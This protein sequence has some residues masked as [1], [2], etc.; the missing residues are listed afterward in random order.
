MRGRVRAGAGDR[1]SRGRRPRRARPRSSSSCS[2]SESVGRLAGRPGDDE[3][4]EPLS[5]RMARELAEAVVV[6]RAV[7]PRNGVNDRRQDS[8][9]A[10]SGRDWSLPSEECAS[11]P[12]R[13]PRR[14]Q[15]SAACSSASRRPGTNASRESVSWRIVSSSPVAAEQHLL[16]RDEPGQPH[17]VDR[18]AVAHRR[19][20]RLR[21]PRRRVDLRLVVQLDDLRA[22]QVLRRLGGEAH[23]QHRAEREV[24]RDEDRPARARA[25]ARPRRSRSAARSCRRST[26][27]PRSSARSTFADHGVRPGEVDG[28]AR[29]ASSPSSTPSASCP[30]RSSAGPSTDADLA[31][32]SR[33]GA[34]FMPRRPARD[35]CARPPP[36]NRS[37]LGPI[38]A[39]DSRAGSSRTPASSASAAGVDGVDL[40]DDPVERQ[41]LRVGDQRAAEPAHPVRGRLHRERDPALQV[42][43]RALQL[44]LAQVAG[45]DVGDL[46][47]RRSRGTGRGSPRACRRRPRSGRCR[48]TASAKL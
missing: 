25:P 26:G 21:R 29:P 32:R 40:G 16:V 22:R 36:R 20:R 8:R 4:S 45:G 34:T 48:C 46:A 2:S 23:H 18:R 13:Q 39:A 1:R 14:R 38:P 33:R 43:L 10:P 37:S 15:A 27:L 28:I 44:A 11:R 19:R 31:A 3:P 42:L 35:G 7:R 9:R 41:Q 24:R 47:R 5:T 6:D 12:T 30:A 17:G